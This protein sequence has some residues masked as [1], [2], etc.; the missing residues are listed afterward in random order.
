MG[1]GWDGGND[2]MSLVHHWESLG[3]DLEG[4]LPP[5][6]PGGSQDRARGVETPAR[7]RY[8]FQLVEL[9]H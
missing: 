8:R 3:T 2:G 9:E 7:T 4:G 6:A 5:C 1:C